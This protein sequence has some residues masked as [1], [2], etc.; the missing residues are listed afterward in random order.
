VSSPRYDLLAIDLDG[1]LINS[2]GRISQRSIDALHEA[3][4]RGMGVMICTGRGLAECRAFLEAIGQEDAVAV[5]GG[6]IIAD[7]TTARTLHR[8][9]MDPMLVSEAARCMIEHDHPALVLKDPLTAGFDYL[10][11][12]GEHRLPLD[13]VM[14]W[15]FETMNLGVRY[16]D[17]TEGD[18]H[19]AHTVRVGA[20]GF[21]DR[22]A[23]IADRLAR[24]MHG[25]AQWHHFPAVVGPGHNDRLAK[26]QAFHILE[27][28]DADANKW[29]A[30]RW[31]AAQ[32]GIDPARI[33]AIGDEI[34]DVSMIEGAGL[35]IAMGNAIDRV[36]ACAG[37]I[38][39]RYDDDG[40]AR[41]IERILRGEW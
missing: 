27:L 4:A 41:A 24:E 6:S 3:R 20:F 39:E 38:T 19:P 14:E 25:R 18:E 40:A 33:A 35:G 37:R 12:R 9:A 21:D 13:P 23:I 34:N 22:V 32:R 8:F 1:T 10:V 15:W 16:T 5:A 36:K 11:V 7:P 28:F 31:F 17:T 26:G 2:S 29:S 30:V